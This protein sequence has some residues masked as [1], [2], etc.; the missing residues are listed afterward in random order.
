MLRPSRAPLY[1][2]EDY[3]SLRRAGQLAAACLDEIGAHVRPGVTT[4][5]LDAICEGFIRDHGAAPAPLGYRGFPRAT[6]ISLNRVVCHGIPG[7]RR[8][9]DG[10]I[11]NIDVT[12]I[13]DGWF[14]DSSRMYVAGRAKPAARRLINVVYGALASGLAMIR[15][16]ATIG[17]IGAAIQR[18]TQ[19]RRCSV[20]R[21][22]CGHGTGRIFHDAPSVPHFG[23]PGAGPSLVAGMVFTVEP[24][25]NLGGFE[26]R[27]LADGWTAV[28]RD[29]SLSAQCEHTIGVT[30]GGCEI[31]TESP[32]GRFHPFAT[33]KN[34]AGR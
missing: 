10:D 7:P 19:E 34:P 11:L 28:T 3:V 16:G 30:A 23:R 15:P 25:I 14:G 13:L 20:V 1:T 4:G 24:M 17:D 31:F 2:R 21:D 8:L 5:E 6:C 26:T 12:V 33:E 18:Y 32:T 9:R 22:Y 27:V 29:G